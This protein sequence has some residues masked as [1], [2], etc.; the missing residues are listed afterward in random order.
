MYRAFLEV[1]KTG[2][3]IELLEILD[4]RQAEDTKRMLWELFEFNVLFTLS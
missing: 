1:R 3:V 2:N 4:N